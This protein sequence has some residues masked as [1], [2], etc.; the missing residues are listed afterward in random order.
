[1]GQ[2]DKEGSHLSHR[3]S[4]PR[5]IGTPCPGSS[6]LLAPGEE[7]GDDRGSLLP[8][9]GL[10]LKLLVAGGGQAVI[11]GPAVMIRDAPIGGDRA[12]LLKLKKRRIERSIVERQSISA[13]LLDAPG[14]PV[15]VQR[16]HD[17]Q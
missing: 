12:L 7:R 5:L 8:L 13:D 9:G 6:G 1:T 15:A 3:G 4:S 11:L 14:D 10:L 16:S 2:A 17:I